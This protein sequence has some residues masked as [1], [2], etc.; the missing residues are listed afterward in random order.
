MTAAGHPPAAFLAEAWSGC[1]GQIVP[2]ERWLEAAYREARAAGALC[3]ADEV[4]TG[5]GRLG[6]HRWAFDQQGALPDIVTLGKPIGNGH[7]LGAV[8]TT[9]GIAAAFNNGMEYFNTFGGNP[10]SCATG[11]A[12]LEILERDDL[13][14][15]AEQVGEALLKGLRSLA[16]R[17]PLIGAELVGSIHGLPKATLDCI[18]HH[19]ES[20]DGSGYPDGLAGTLSQ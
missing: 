4:Q 3:I 11:L 8:I 9:A 7:P 6:S 18:R 15:H 5:F 12:V 19:H 10:V 20:W 16:E 2:P 14:D 13:Q 17:H 1:G